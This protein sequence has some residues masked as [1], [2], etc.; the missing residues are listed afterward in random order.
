MI[1]AS[2]ACQLN[3]S[4]KLMFDIGTIMQLKRFVTGGTV[5]CLIRTSE[6]SAIVHTT[7]MLGYQREV[8]EHKCW[9][10]ARHDGK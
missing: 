5:P 4:K 9:E 1:S 7:T 6:Y 8:C 2:L 10:N 3:T